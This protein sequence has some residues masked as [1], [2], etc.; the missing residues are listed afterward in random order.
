MIHIILRWM[1]ENHRGHSDE[2]LK[3]EADL[4]DNSTADVHII[5]EDVRETV[6]VSN[7]ETGTS[8]S[9]CKDQPI[10][11]IISTEPLSVNLNS[12]NEPAE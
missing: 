10:D 3:Y 7:G 1:S 2:A 5:I 8:L 11:P 9:S 4:L 6:K 12:A